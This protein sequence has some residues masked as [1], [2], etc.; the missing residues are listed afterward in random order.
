MLLFQEVGE[1]DLDAHS[2]HTSVRDKKVAI[3]S[4]NLAY[5]S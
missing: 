2:Q 5:F 1:K 3:K 4:G